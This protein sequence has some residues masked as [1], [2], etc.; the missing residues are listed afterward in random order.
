MFWKS[1]PFYVNL[2]ARGKSYKIAWISYQE[3]SLAPILYYGRI[4]L[5]LE[6]SLL[7]SIVSLSSAT[8]SSCSSQHRYR[9]QNHH[10]GFYHFIVINVIDTIV[11]RLVRQKSLVRHKNTRFDT[12]IHAATQ[13]CK[14]RQKNGLT[15]MH[16]LPLPLS[17]TPLPF[18]WEIFFFQ[19][20]SNS[21]FL[22]THREIIWK[23][24]HIEFKYN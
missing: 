11:I 5:C 23:S 19:F 1:A 17:N 22:R 12:K 21:L 24:N 18:P 10:H 16:Q 14:V 8:S 4:T 2:T 7:L 9:H 15:S 3:F 13:Q 20:H 6:N